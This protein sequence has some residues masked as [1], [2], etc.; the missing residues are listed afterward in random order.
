VTGGR[1]TRVV[2]FTRFTV[3]EL[4]IDE[5]MMASFQ[6]LANSSFTYPR[7]IKHYLRS[8]DTGQHCEVNTQNEDRQVARNVPKKKKNVFGNHTISTG[9]QFQPRME[10]AEKCL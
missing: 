8:R 6:I 1:L 4:Y 3:P 7:I 2:N 5:A 9:N 10:C